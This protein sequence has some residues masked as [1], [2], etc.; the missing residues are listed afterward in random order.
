MHTRAPDQLY[1]NPALSP[2]LKLLEGLKTRPAVSRFKVQ[3]N[4]FTLELR[5]HAVQPIN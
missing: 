2:V 1:Y 4:D 5:S 3:K